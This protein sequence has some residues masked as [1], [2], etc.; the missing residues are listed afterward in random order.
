MLWPGGR[1]VFFNGENSFIQYQ[2]NIEDASMVKKMIN[3]WFRTTQ[4][5][6]VMLSMFNANLSNVL[7]VGLRDGMLKLE[8]G[9]KTEYQAPN[10]HIWGK[11]TFADGDWHH[12]WLI[13]TNPTFQYWWM[14]AS[15]GSMKSSLDFFELF[16]A[17]RIFLGGGLRPTDTRYRGCLKLVEIGGYEWGGD[18]LRTEVN[19]NNDYFKVYFVL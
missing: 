13:M 14:D 4:K 18:V 6:N 19:E 17:N 8:I 10:Y 2:H 12:L 16:K 1:D 5:D 7:T 3:I 15:M 9:D 11:K